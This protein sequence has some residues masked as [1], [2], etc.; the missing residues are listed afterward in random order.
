MDTHIELTKPY[1][2]VRYQ[3]SSK[4]QFLRVPPR[5]ISRDGISPILSATSGLSGSKWAL[6][7]DILVF[8]RYVALAIARQN[9]CGSK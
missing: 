9:R 2:D 4:R 3:G 6:L 8:P 5:K 1:S 7:G